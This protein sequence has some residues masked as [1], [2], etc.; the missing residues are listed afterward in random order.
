MALRPV[1][2]IFDYFACKE[3]TPE[4]YETLLQD[5]LEGDLTLFMRSDQVEEAWDVVTTIQEDWANKKAIFP[6]YE[7]EAGVRKKVLIWLKDKVTT[8]CNI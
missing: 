5:A 2:M 1:E 3:D 4:A 7:A 6:N 8:G